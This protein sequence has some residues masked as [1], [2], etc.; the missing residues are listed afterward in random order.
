MD[1]I[2]LQQYILLVRGLTA[3]GVPGQYHDCPLG[4][5]YIKGRGIDYEG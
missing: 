5:Q 2:E 1:Y 4:R 3:S